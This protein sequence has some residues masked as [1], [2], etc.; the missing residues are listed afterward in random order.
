M[1]VLSRKLNESIVIDSNIT[2]TVTQIEGDRVKIGIVA[3]R[4]VNIRRSEIPKKDQK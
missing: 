1:L 3:P 4:E 2:I